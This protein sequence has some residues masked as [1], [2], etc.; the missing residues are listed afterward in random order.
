VKD[1]KL[2]MYLTKSTKRDINTWGAKRKHNNKNIKEK[3]KLKL[4]REIGPTDA[5]NSKGENKRLSWRHN[6]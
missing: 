2:K 4:E 5:Q 1:E 3:L 6:F